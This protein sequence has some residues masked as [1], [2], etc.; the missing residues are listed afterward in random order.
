MGPIATNPPAT[1]PRPRHTTARCATAL[2]GAGAGVRVERGRSLWF[3]VEPLTT[4]RSAEFLIR[5]AVAVLLKN[6][7]RTSLTVEHL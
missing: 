1:R 5:R 7:Q 6:L 3:E 2:I 4:H